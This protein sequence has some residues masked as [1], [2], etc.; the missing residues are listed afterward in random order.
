MQNKKLKTSQDHKFPNMEDWSLDSVETYKDLYKQDL[1]EE[2]MERLESLITEKKHEQNQLTSSQEDDKEV[3]DLTM[4][5]PKDDYIDLTYTDDEE[6]DEGLHFDNQS[7]YSDC[8]SC[9]HYTDSDWDEELETH[10]R[11]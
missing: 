11:D 3:I 7:Q 4:W 10:L 2:D 6:E 5:D 8:Y 9:N 1:T